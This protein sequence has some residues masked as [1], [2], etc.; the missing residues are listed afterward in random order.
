MALVPDGASAG[1][2]PAPPRLTL[3]SSGR[4]EI[5][6]DAIDHTLM[7]MFRELVRNFS[8]EENMKDEELKHDDPKRERH[9]RIL[10]NLERTL[11]RI[12]HFESGRAAARKS[13]AAVTDEDARRS[14][15]ARIDSI[16]IAE[17]KR[18]DIKTVW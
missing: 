15:E 16:L 4:E 8:I 18:A 6:P 11:E 12:A 17:F 3:V 1:K 13:R 10:A 14:L 2:T 7:R 5:N 9:A